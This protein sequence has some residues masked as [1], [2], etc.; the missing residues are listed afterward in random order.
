MITNLTQGWLITHQKCLDG[1][2]AAVVG[3]SCGLRPIFT[4]PDRVVDALSQVTDDRPLYLADVSLPVNLWSTHQSRI[5][6]L[7]DHHQT[8]LP[9][10]HDPKAI[11]D[12]SHCGAALMYRFVL[13]A[14]W[15]TSSA[16][17]DRLIHA[18]ERYDLW[19]PHHGPGQDLNRLFRARGF[20]WYQS[21]FSEGWSPFTSDEAEQLARIIYDETEFIA[22]HVEAA[23]RLTAG[24][25]TLAGVLLEREGPVNEVAH[26]LLER[27]V[28]M[29]LFLKLDGRLSARTR[30]T[31]DAATLME[32]NF[33]GGGHARAAGGRISPDMT[34]SLETLRDLLEEIRR[35]LAP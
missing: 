7:L 16:R 32:T 26:H 31:V 21:R 34:A 18:V 15:L 9:L 6:Y 19:Q 30:P 10:R 3:L 28:D 12:M 23:Q 4:E 27:G 25:L 20:D 35:S 29:V 1:A 8:A 17:W 5:T 14:G 24:T 11:V 2:T 13:Q 33:G 22:Q